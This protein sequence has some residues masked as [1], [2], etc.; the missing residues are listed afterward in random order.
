MIVRVSV[1]RAIICV[2]NRRQRV[3][4][5]DLVPFVSESRIIGKRPSGRPRSGMLDR[6]KDGDPYVVVKRRTL[7]R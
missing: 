5:G 2:I 1:V 7:Y 3:W 6:E 4:H